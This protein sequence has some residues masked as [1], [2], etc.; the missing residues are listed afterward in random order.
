MK[1]EIQSNQKSNGVVTLAIQGEVDTHTSPQVLEQWKDLLKD[2][3]SAVIINLSGV[4]YINSLGLS[5]L[6]EGMQASQNN[7]TKFLLASLSPM[8]KDVFA[9]AHLLTVFEIYDSTED[10]LNAI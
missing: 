9:M 3:P 4:T 2:N 6:V 10:A 7:N 1:I 5:T 8:V